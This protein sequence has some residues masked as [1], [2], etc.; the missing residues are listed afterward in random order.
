MYWDDLT[1]KAF[2]I[3]SK[4]HMG[5]VDKAGAPYILHPLA[6]AKDMP[7]SEMAAAALLHD[8]CEDTPV[9]L[10][11]LREQGIPEIVVQAVKLLTHE[12][13]LS[14]MKYIERLK[15][16]EIASAVKRADLR[17]NSSPSRKTTPPTQKDE[18][19]LRRYQKALRE[20]FAAYESKGMPAYAVNIYGK[21]LGSIAFSRAN[22][23]VARGVARQVCFDPIVILVYDESVLKE[24]E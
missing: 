16:D 8:V 5:Q 3:A 12:P 4:A 18:E 22:G 10:D 17:H 19:R 21:P 15:N 11:N 20:L 2:E 9:T 14:Y 23:L 24:G 6:V 7:T 13:G 1:R